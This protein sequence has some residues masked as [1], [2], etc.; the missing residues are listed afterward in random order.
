MDFNIAVFVFGI[1]FVFLWEMKADIFL[2]VFAISVYVFLLFFL[3]ISDPILT[4]QSILNLLISNP[5]LAILLLLSPLG[6]H[7]IVLFIKKRKYNQSK[8]KI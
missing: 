7:Y 5:F 4:F 6:I 1:M 3:I 8:Q 2:L